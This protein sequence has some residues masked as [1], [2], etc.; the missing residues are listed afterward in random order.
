MVTATRETEH[1]RERMS[2]YLD[3]FLERETAA[4]AFLGED[5]DLLRD[6]LLGFVRHGG[7]RLRPAFVHWGYRAAGGA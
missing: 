7:K 5:L 2:R 4:L 3:E 6:T 1:L